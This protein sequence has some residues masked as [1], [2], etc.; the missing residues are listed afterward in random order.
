MY[1]GNIIKRIRDTGE[2]EEYC[3]KI[4]AKNVIKTNC[5]T[6]ETYLNMFRYFKDNSIFHITYQIKDERT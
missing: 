5:V 3:T 2:D 1:Y 6:P 4:L